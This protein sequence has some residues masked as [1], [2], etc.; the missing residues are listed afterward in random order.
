MGW[1]KQQALRAAWPSASSHRLGAA[2]M[3]VWRQSRCIAV[4]LEEWHR[5]LPGANLRPTSA[6]ILKQFPHP[7]VHSSRTRGLSVIPFREETVRLPETLLSGTPVAG[8]R[9]EESTIHRLRSLESTVN[10]DSA[11]TSSARPFGVHSGRWPTHHGSMDQGSSPPGQLLASGGKPAASSEVDAMRAAPCCP[12]PS[13]A[14]P[15]ACSPLTNRFNRDH[16]HSSRS[17]NPC[18]PPPPMP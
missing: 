18:V 17:P 4:R 8:Y 13:Y 15:T 1:C 7:A 2:A 11:W 16:G 14:S 9:S 6:E 12:G 10:S 5:K 3:A